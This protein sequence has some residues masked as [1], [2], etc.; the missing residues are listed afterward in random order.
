MHVPPDTSQVAPG[1][2]HVVPQQVWVSAPQPPQLPAL[3]TPPPSTP[4]HTCDSLTQ[5][6]I[7]LTVTQQP[8]PLHALPA[9]QGSV[10]PPHAW[11]FAPLQEAP[12]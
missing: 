5:R 1:A 6:R 2:L 11:Q 9:Q 4:V 7:P 10:T 8:P 12:D 3:Q